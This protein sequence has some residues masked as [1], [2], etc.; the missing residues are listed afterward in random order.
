MQKARILVVED[1]IIIAME[2]EYILKKL[3]YAVTSIVNNG[4]D[5]IKSAGEEKPDLI[6]MDIRIQGDK[7]GIET[8]RIIRQKTDIPV[9]FTTAFLDEER[10][11]KAEF[12]APFRYIIKP[13]QEENLKDT[14]EMV[15]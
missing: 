9:V 6:L 4:D 3:G 7:D 10:I 8:A 15:L 13:I 12:Q 14:L 11:E 2:I 1:E 5:A